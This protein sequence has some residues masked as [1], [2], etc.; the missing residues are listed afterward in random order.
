[1][2]NDLNF[3]TLFLR[4]LHPGITTTENDKLTLEQPAQG[5]NKIIH[6]DS[7]LTKL[8]LNP[9]KNKRTP[10]YLDSQKLMEMMMKVLPTKGGRSKMEKERETRFSLTNCWTRRQRPADPTSH[11]IQHYFTSLSKN[12]PSA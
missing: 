11:R 5:I 9:H 4:N 3:K 1:M 7:K 10:P 12:Q 6:K 2:E 8:K